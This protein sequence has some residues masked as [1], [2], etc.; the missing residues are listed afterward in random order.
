[1]NK[2]L[3]RAIIC[4]IGILFVIAAWAF[5]ASR[6]EASILDSEN[7]RFPSN[8]PSDMVIHIDEDAPVFEA[9]LGPADG[10]GLFKVHQLR[11]VKVYGLDWGYSRTRK[12]L[13]SGT[14]NPI[15]LESSELFIADRALSNAEKAQLFLDMDRNPQ[16]Y[17]VTAK[18]E[19]IED[20]RGEYI[21]WKVTGDFT[22]TVVTYASKDPKCCIPIDYT[23]LKTQINKKKFAF[24]IVGKALL[25][26]AVYAGA[27]LLF[28][29]VT[30]RKEKKQR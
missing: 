14:F 2:V 16:E 8:L 18:S 3:R 26:G 9:V 12:G 15:D 22:G 24:P 27:V 21:R 23:D 7:N 4:F 11:E 6:F 5:F 28:A 25:A 1:M 13:V 17:D 20:D 19:Y 30:G 29:K 10:V